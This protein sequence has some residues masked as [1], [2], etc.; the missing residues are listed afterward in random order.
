[1]R[2]APGSEHRDIL[3]DLWADEAAK[4]IV[5]AGADFDV[6]YGGDIGSGR[7]TALTPSPD[8]CRV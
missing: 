4:K 1:M 7:I 3:L 6:W 2:F 8:R 5:A